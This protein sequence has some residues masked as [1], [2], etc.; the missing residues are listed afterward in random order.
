MAAWFENLMA[1]LPLNLPTHELTY[2]LTK[3]FTGIWKTLISDVEEKSVN[4]I[5]YMTHDSICFSQN[6]PCTYI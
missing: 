6:F 3:W 2:Q 5:V 4:Y 1:A